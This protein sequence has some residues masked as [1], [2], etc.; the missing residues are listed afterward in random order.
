MRLNLLFLFLLGFTLSFAQ[1]SEPAATPTETH[2]SEPYLHQEKVTESRKR[3]RIV[4]PGGVNIPEIRVVVPEVY[5]P[6]LDIDIKREEIV[7]EGGRVDIPE[8]VI[9]H[10][11][12]DWHGTTYTD[13]YMGVF[14][15]NVSEEKALILGYDNPHGRQVQRVIDETPA[16]RAGLR[17]F[18]YIYGVDEY[19]VGEQ[20]HLS[21]IIS[22]YDPGDRAVLKV[23]RSGNRVEVPITFGDRNEYRDA[24]ANYQRCD[25]PFLGVRHYRSAQRAEGG[26]IIR[27]I[28]GTTA[29]DMGILSDDVIVGID[30]NRVYDWT[31]VETGVRSH[32]RGD[33]IQ[34]SV[35]RDGTRKTMTGT[36]KSRRDVGHC[37]EDDD[38]DDDNDHEF[39]YQTDY[40]TAL[41]EYLND[42]KEERGL[43]TDM[44]VEMEEVSEEEVTEM[45]DRYDVEMPTQ[46]TL[47]VRDLDVYPN[48]SMGMFNVSFELPTEG[49]TLIR[50]FNA[51][52][53]EIYE[54]DLGNF[55]GRF[56][57]TIDLSQN[58][59]GA[60]FLVVTQ[61]AQTLTKK[62]VLS[63]Q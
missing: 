26:V 35:E 62:I 61:G 33:R 23:I 8:V 38:D 31:D 56:D 1:Q 50:V 3:I 28:E 57:D 5:I 52:G 17:G 54:Y 12:K 48:P 47:P 24:D 30:G 34:V 43:V 19:R 37:D 13:T 40:P 41:N 32:K 14:L 10:R 46:N 55:G 9:D 22:R 16:A 42:L 45:R 63:R 11:S 7:I 18:D 6:A 4:K 27:M 53:R 25:A 60:Y 20:Q 44:E 2:D 58:G 15:E 39:D 36:L 51:Q 29:N 49:P 59:T 21:G